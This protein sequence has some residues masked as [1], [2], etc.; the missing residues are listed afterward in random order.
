LNMSNQTTT[1]FPRT[2][3]RHMHPQVRPAAGELG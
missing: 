3:A 1:I 2:C